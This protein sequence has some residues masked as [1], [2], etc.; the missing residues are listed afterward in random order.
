MQL[1]SID[2]TIEKDKLLIKLK[3]SIGNSRFITLI[4]DINEL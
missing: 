1:E 4:S 2:A 3:I